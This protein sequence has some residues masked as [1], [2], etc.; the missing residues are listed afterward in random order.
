MAVEIP[1]LADL[2]RRAATD[3]QAALPAA[4]P[5]LR[6]TL[7]QAIVFATTGRTYE[8]YQQLRILEREIFPDSASATVNQERWGALKG[9]T[10][11]LASKASGFICATG[12]LGASIPLGAGFRA[13]ESGAYTSLAEATIA[14]ASLAVASM[15]RLGSTVTV[16]TAVDHQLAGNVPV[17]ISGANEAGYDGVQT[18]MVTGV[19]TFTYQ[20]ATTPTTPATGT[21]MAAAR[22]ASLQVQSDGFGD[23]QNVGP[24]T[25]LTLASP[26]TG[27]DNDARVQFSEISGGTDAETNE[28]FRNRYLFDYANPVAQFNEAAIIKAAREVAGVTEVFVHPVTPGIGDVTVYFLRGNDADIIPSAQEVAD[29]R[30]ALLAIY[31]VHSDESDLYVLAPIAHPVD[32]TFTALNPTSKSLQDQIIANLTELFRSQTSVGDVMEEDA[33]RSA[34]FNTMTLDGFERVTSFELSQPLGDIAPAADAIPT[35]GSVT[36]AI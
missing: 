8:A 36:F 34:I 7:L 25:T 4:N 1:T 19:D 9:V 17:T 6:E 23:A 33:F 22:F 18:I 31:P 35:L 13:G 11:L 27:I 24:D 14:D 21:M 10:P 12:T 28:D 5:T 3:I 15:T 16:Q 30:A 20:I 29:V 26:I 2:S 32:F